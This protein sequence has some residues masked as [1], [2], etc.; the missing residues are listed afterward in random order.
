MLTFFEKKVN[1]LA[2]YLPTAS[3][4][5]I[6]RGGFQEEDI[7][8]NVD[9]ESQTENGQSTP[10]PRSDTYRIVLSLEEESIVPALNASVGAHPHVSFGSYPIVDDPEYKTIITL[11]G[12]FYNGGYTKGSQRFLEKSMTD[13]TGNGSSNKVE[14]KNQIQAIFFSKPAEKVHLPMPAELALKKHER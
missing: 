5:L 2:T 6:P 14:E 13:K 4:T 11:E 12:R 10:P 7:G 8:L 1:Q 9:Q 3:S